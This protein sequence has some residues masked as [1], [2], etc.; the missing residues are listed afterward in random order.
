MQRAARGFFILLL[1]EGHAG[2]GLSS[3]TLTLRGQMGAM[4]QCV[5]RHTPE[6]MFWIQITCRASEYFP[7]SA[8]LTQILLTFLNDV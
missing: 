1:S 2:T 4:G 3:H 5:F 8:A 7:S 6:R